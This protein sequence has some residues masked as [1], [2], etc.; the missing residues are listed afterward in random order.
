LK[1]ES[2]LVQRCSVPVVAELLDDGIT[3]MHTPGHVT[4]CVVRVEIERLYDR[5]ARFTCQEIIAYEYR[6]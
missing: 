6:S 4:I 2:L 5:G 1:D 3:Q